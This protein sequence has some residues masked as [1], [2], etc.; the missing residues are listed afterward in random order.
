MQLQTEISSS[1]ERR[2]YFAL[3]LGERLMRKDN[4]CRKYIP[5]KTRLKTQNNFLFEF[6]RLANVFG[7]SNNRF[8]LFRTTTFPGHLRYASS[9]LD[10]ALPVH[11]YYSLLTQLRSAALGTIHERYP[12]QDWL[13]V[14]NDGSSTASFGRAGA[15][16][17]SNSLNLKEPFSAWSDNFNG[18]DAASTLP[19]EA[20]S[21]RQAT[22]QGHIS[23]EKNFHSYRP[24]C[25]LIL[26]LSARWQRR[27][28][29]SS[30]PRVE[31]VACFRIITGN[32]YLQGYR[33]II[34]LDDSPLYPL[35]K[36]VPKTGEHLS[37]CPAL[38]HVLSQDNCRVLLP[39]RVTSAS[40]WT[41]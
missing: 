18:F 1:S 30:L 38:L 26:F 8:P 6:Q 5:S 11:N 36:S 21:K 40:H 19:S 16:S 37:D 15:V 9:N 34:G 31:G 10:L 4:F 27:A 32:D 22:S 39:A 28:Q 14:F 13:H 33:F 2:H 29:L 23:P 3:S 12:D 41:A 24:G 25:W 35:C 7:V 20:S 17:F